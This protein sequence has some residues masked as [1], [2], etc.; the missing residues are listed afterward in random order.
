V[1]VVGISAD[2]VATHQ[3]FKAAKRLKFILLADEQ[4]D[5]ARLFGVPLRAGGTT[6][7]KDAQGQVVRDASGGVVRVARQFTAAR[8]TF[9]ID[10]NGVIVSIE[11]SV[12]PRYDSQ[13]V[14]ATAVQLANR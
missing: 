1:T 10:K 14:L 3:L 12:S 11:K 2:Q 7:I 8:W 4:G 5:V 9:V 13:Q 6:V